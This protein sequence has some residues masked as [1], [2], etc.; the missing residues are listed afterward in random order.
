MW[1][2]VTP[3]SSVI[4]IPLQ[5]NPCQ[6]H[7]L[8]FLGSPLSPLSTAHTYMGHGNL[9]VT[10]SSRGMTFPSPAIVHG[11]ELF[12]EDW[13]LESIYPTCVR[14]FVQLNSYLL[15]AHGCHNYVMS[16][17]QYFTTL[18]PSCSHQGGNIS[19]LKY[20]PFVQ[21]LAFSQYSE[22]T[23]KQWTLSNIS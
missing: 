11:E 4:H 21:K 20:S 10:S 9:P 23:P 19:F 5:Y 1:S 2:H 3:F 14:I 18:L 6:L 12:C 8:F 13:G 22:S 16:R 17:K 15:W 7:V